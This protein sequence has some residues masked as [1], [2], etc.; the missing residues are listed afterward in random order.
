MDIDLS[1]TRRLHGADTT[2]R[3]LRP[4]G[5]SGEAATQTF[6]HQLTPYTTHK[7]LHPGTAP[8]VLHQPASLE[9]S[10]NEKVDGLEMKIDSKLSEKSSMK[11]IPEA[12]RVTEEHWKTTLWK[13]IK[14]NPESQLAAAYTLDA[15]VMVCSFG[16]IYWLKLQFSVYAKPLSYGDAR[17]TKSLLRSSTEKEKKDLAQE[18]T[19]E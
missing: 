18:Q 9:S 3:P 2:L 4:C 16:T 13:N 5:Q 19:N 8:S 10:N 1:H 7:Q 6:S 17:N 11:S 15:P 14:P 12:L